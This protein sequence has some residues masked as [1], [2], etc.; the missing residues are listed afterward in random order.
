MLATLLPKGFITFLAALLCFMSSRLAVL[1]AAPSL[2]SVPLDAT[3]ETELL[4][5]S[6]L[7]FGE[8]RPALEAAGRNDEKGG[9]ASFPTVHNSGREKVGKM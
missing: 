9:G 7:G 1:Q 3:K 5:T 6:Q 2:L 4:E 8:I